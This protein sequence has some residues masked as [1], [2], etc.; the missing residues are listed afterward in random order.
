VFSAGA[1]T[2]R[3]KLNSKW[4]L[5]STCDM[6]SSFE[7]SY[8]NSAFFPSCRL[9]RE[10][11]AQ[12]RRLYTPFDTDMSMP[13]D[14][15]MS[16][17][18]DGSMSM[19]LDVDITMPLDVDMHRPLDVDMSRPL[20]ET[21]KSLDFTTSMPAVSDEMAP[22]CDESLPSIPVPIDFEVQTGAPIDAV[23]FLTGILS[24]AIAEDFTLC[25]VSSRKFSD[26][27]RKLKES[28]VR[29]V[30]ILNV[31]EVDG[32]KSWIDPASL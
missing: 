7:C 25:A 30:E 2:L 8:L 11:Q 29:S 5:Y 14:G 10:K 19:H 12:F 31:T 21:K 20:D 24:T 6:D 3:K 28:I 18:F 9:F 13:F 1:T 23:G 22:V 4:T 26:K 27:E 15:S 16:M 17:P 32:G